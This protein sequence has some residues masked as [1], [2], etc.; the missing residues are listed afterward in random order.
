MDVTCSHHTQNEK[1]K[2]N[3]SAVALSDRRHQDTELNGV[4]EQGSVHEVS[5][6]WSQALSKV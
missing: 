4:G 3:A 1:L 6:T 2:A 5:W